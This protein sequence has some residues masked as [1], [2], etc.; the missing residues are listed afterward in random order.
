MFCKY[1]I[2]F[3]QTY[4]TPTMKEIHEEF[5]VLIFLSQIFIQ[6]VQDQIFQK[7]M[8]VAP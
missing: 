3:I 1:A 5:L 2:F 4:K 7:E 6:G 8:A